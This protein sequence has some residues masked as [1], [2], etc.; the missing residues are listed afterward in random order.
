MP[1]GRPLED[2][3]AVC[4]PGRQASEGTSPA[5]ARLSGSQPPGRER[6]RVSDLAGPWGSAV[7]LSGVGQEP[8]LLA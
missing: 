3:T 6:T 4:T 2:T 8:L 1:E 5:D 7:S